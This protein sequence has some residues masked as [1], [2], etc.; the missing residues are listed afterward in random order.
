MN[1]S[2]ALMNDT[3]RVTYTNAVQLPYLDMALRDLEE[4]FQLHNIPV[5]N[6][7]S[8]TLTPLVAGTTVVSFTSSPALPSDLVEIQQLY[9]R[10]TGVEPWIPMSKREFLPLELEAQDITQ[11]LI[12]AWVN[13]EIRLIAS[14]A[15]NDL[16]MDYI[17]SIFVTPV[18]IADIDIDIAI[19]NIHQYLGY[20]VAALC[21]RYIGSNESRAAMLEGQANEAL[22]RE[23]GI[24]I[25]GK[26]SITTRR[27]PFMGS[28][29][30][31]GFVS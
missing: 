31:S 6:A 1:M 17:A 22:E 14:T 3:N 18:D 8:A 5:T 7:T 11:F 28:Y 13:Q 30:R 20:H 9:E 10:T 16:K 24:P 27:R 23:L 4:I 12:W 29:R 19:V 26:Q 25:K 21:S 2:A 15:S